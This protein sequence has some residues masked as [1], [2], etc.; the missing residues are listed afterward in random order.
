MNVLIEVLIKEI[1]RG[2]NLRLD[3]SEYVL[4]NENEKILKDILYKELTKP[5]IEQSR[6][7]T[8]IVNEFLYEKFNESFTLTPANFGEK[9]HKLIM[10]WGVQKAKDI[11]EQ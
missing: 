9:A 7:P 4:E 2:V 10:E 5:S 11:S 1:I 8:Q 3:N 6:T